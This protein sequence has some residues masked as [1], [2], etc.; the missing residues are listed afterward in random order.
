MIS[1]E[2][3]ANSIERLWKEIDQLTQ[4]QLDAFSSAIFVGMS[5]AE[6]KQCDAR[7]DYIRKLV[8]ELWYRRAAIRN[9]NV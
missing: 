1:Q 5:P 9:F 4:E 3:P 7:Q 2:D 6:A 8:E